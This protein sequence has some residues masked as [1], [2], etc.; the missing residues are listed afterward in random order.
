MMRRQLSPA[1]GMGGQEGGVQI[2]Q[3]K[4]M[5]MSLQ[6][7]WEGAAVHHYTCNLLSLLEVVQVGRV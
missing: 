7:L 6:V 3:M 4:G 1:M 5:S 2:C